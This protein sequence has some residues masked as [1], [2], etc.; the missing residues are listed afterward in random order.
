MRPYLQSDRTLEPS[1]LPIGRCA[2]LRP[3]AITL[4]GLLTCGLS[5]SQRPGG[6]SGLP[7]RFLL[8]IGD[9]WK[10]PA[11]TVIEGG[12][13][14]NT[15]AALLKSW[16]LPF[17]IWRLDQ[18]RLDK[19]HLLDRDGR[20]RY[21]TIIWD[22]SA[23]QARDQ[24][25]E[26]V[27]E[28]VTSDAVNLLVLG[29]A[30]SVPAISALAGVRYI[31]GFISRDNPVVSRE[32]FITRGLN[33][34][35]LPAGAYWPGYKVVAEN[36]TP[37]MTRGPHPFLTVRQPERG[38]R[39]VW[40]GVDRPGNQ[41]QRQVARDL[42]K[43]ALVWAQGYALYADY[44]KTMVLFMDDPGTSDKTYLPYWSYLTPTEETIRRSLI[45]PL[46][47]H[48]AVLTPDVTTG[49]VDRK[50]QRILNPW[51]QD[52]VADE[53]VPGRVHDF[54]STKRGLDAGVR[55]GV[56]EIQAH[57]WTHILPDLDSPPG[58]F[59]TAPMDGVGSYN[60]YQEF[61]DPDIRK[62]EV[63][64]IW[65]AFHMRRAIECLQEDF[66]IRPQFIM[67]PG[68]GHGTSFPNHSAR[69]AAQMGFGLSYFGGAEYLDPEIVLSLEPI[70]IFRTWA[71]DRPFFE[72][73]WTPDAPYFLLFHDRD[74]SLD[75]VWPERLLEHLGSG[76]NYMTAS[77]YSAYLHAKVEG[78]GT[79][80][81]IDYDPYYCRFFASAKSKWVLHLSD[82]VR[83]AAAPAA[84]ER[85]IIDIPAG[86][87]RHT[88]P[89]GQ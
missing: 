35:L 70:V 85:Q 56:F 58:P 49:Y 76:V 48:H 73:S 36:A 61:G 30:L 23:E 4:L 53:L 5:P 84:P 65:Q 20:P 64:A 33:G 45:G 72:I 88:I 29:D 89:M 46:K 60:W 78:N 12:D 34:D 31:S 44:S 25:V 18:Q 43:R 86:A 7:Y 80:M 17:E 37:V 14:F 77:E 40:L 52:R 13:E 9:Q 11:S 67:V 24:G 57:G 19:Y 15:A 38:G 21:G 41:L 66:G 42:F 59:W 79:A 68:S 8:V 39:V 69:I 54:A 3:I 81:A 10:D 26:L 27:A 74:V 16:G 28:L 75:P 82:E 6:P 71:Y 87:G 63:P 1:I 22:A 62:K 51:R 2:V 32:H 47:Q 83:R 55:E 50:S